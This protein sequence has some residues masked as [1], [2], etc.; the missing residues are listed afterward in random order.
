[1]IQLKCFLDERKNGGSCMY[2]CSVPL[3][4][5]EYS[6]SVTDIHPFCVALTQFLVFVR[7][8]NLPLY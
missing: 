5:H 2:F 6:N 8:Q 4:T 3:Y 1:M 7:G